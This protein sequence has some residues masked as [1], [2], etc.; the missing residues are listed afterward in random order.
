MYDHA[1]VWSHR[2]HLDIVLEKSGALRE[3]PSAVMELLDALRL[4]AIHVDEKRGSLLGGFV[5]GERPLLQFSDDVVERAQSLT[6][7]ADKESGIGGVYPEELLGS[8]GV[9]FDALDRDTEPLEK[10]SYKR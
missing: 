1:L 9:F 2:R 6:A 3:Q 5:F 4:I 8:D 7:A 10:V